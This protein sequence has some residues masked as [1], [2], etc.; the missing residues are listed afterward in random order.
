MPGYNPEK[1]NIYDLTIEGPEKRRDFFD[2]EA[3]ITKDDWKKMIE[4]MELCRMPGKENWHAFYAD[5]FPL[6]ILN[7]EINLS[8]DERAVE[9]MRKVL[10]TD[11]IS[12]WSRAYIEDLMRAKIF[13]PERGFERL[14]GSVSWS[15]LKDV[16]NEDRQ[17]ESW[18]EFFSLAASMKFFKPDIDLD[19]KEKDWQDGITAAT[20]LKTKA[21]SG[22]PGGYWFS[23]SSAAMP[24]KLLNPE[25]DFN[26]SSRDWEGM[27]KQLRNH[28]YSSNTVA[29]TDKWRTFS[30]HAMNM[31]ILSAEDIK[32]TD[33][34][35]EII[36]PKKKEKLSFANSEIPEQRNF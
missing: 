32:F 18:E 15:K 16:L 17:F 2:V 24:I 12:K 23:F 28:N 36:M 4:N 7:P 20:I 6:K 35:L 21:E 33:K 5:A 34:G 29:S 30:Y 22:D 1:V 27:T 19:I 10:E 8:L 9:G 31:K 14:T 3:E 11:L 25:V 26:L 13:F